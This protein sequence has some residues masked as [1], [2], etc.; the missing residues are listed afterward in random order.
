MDELE[1]V[2]QRATIMLKQCKKLSYENRFKFP[3]LPTLTYTKYRGD[4]KHKI[5]N[6]LY[7]KDVVPSLTLNN[8]VNAKG[9]SLKS[10]V[11]R[12]HLKKILPYI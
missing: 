4:M 9:N 12:A 7:N 5:L 3:N 2:Q 1:R 8:N 10:S 11:T 6:N